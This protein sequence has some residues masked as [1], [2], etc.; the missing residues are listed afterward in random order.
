MNMESKRILLCTAIAAAVMA[1]CGSSKHAADAKGNV[2]SVAEANAEKGNVP[3]TEMQRYFVRND[4]NGL[5]P[6]KIETDSALNANF[7]MAAAM[8]EGGRPTAVDFSREFCIAVALPETDM[9]TEIIP[10]SLTRSAAGSLVLTYA[11]RRGQ[12]QSYTIRPHLL[13]KASRR[14]DAP[15]ELRQQ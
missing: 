8:G 15:V 7:G 4:V 6:V 2:T 12:K 1:G 5:L 14:Y 10:V 9:A 13:L 3:F 11:V